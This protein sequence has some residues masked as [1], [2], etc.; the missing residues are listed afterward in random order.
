M[1]TAQDLAG[2]QSAKSTLRLEQIAGLRARGVGDHVDLPQLIVCG[3]QSAGK[4]SI[5]EGI[6]GVP[7]PRQDGVCTKFPTEI[8]LRHSEGERIIHATILPTT[9]R[10]EQVREKLQSY[11]HQLESFDELPT[12]IAAA[13]SLMGLRGFEGAKEGPAF[14]QD[15]LRIEVTGPV[16]LHLTVVDLPGLISV[17]NDEQTEVRC[18]GCLDD[19]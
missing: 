10:A 2:L 13:G 3:D 16:G 14:T 17:A 6:T 12:S 4:S 7:F 15:V 11:K 9:S 8:I 18:P 1:S 5:L 19:G